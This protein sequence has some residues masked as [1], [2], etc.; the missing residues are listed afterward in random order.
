MQIAPMLAERNGRAVDDP[1]KVFQVKYDGFRVWAVIRDDGCRLYS[2]NGND[3][4]AAF[5]EIPGPLVNNLSGA[6]SMVLDGEV[7]VF[8]RGKPDFNALQ[9]RVHVQDA[10][11]IRLRSRDMPA[12]FVPFDLP[13]YDGRDLTV[14]GE[15]LPLTRRMAMLEGTV[16]YDGQVTRL[17]IGTDLGG[18]EGFFRYIL[19]EGF[20]GM[21]VKSKAGLYYPGKRHPDWSK[22]KLELSEPFTVIGYT[23]GEGWRAASGVFGSLLIAKG[24]A[25][26]GTVGGGFNNGELEGLTARL[27]AIAC[28]QCPL[29]AVPPREPDFASW[30][31]PQISIEV[32]FAERTKDNRLRFPVCKG[33]RN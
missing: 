26:W 27:K 33:V 24:D 9:K 5:P 15:R 30:V 19:S 20:E 11:K 10:V 29:P 14:A 1:T 2:R 21:M 12:S 16:R 7:A 28:T 32:K 17:A 13:Y 31:L 25:Y 6:H 23:F 8:T 3:V 18:G 22:V 4:T